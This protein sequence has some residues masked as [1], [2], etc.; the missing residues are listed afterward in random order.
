M[1]IKE[2]MHRASEIMFFPNS[3]YPVKAVPYARVLE[4]L[5]NHEGSPVGTAEE[6]VIR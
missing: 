3:D 2:E 1:E 5:N 4:I 6:A